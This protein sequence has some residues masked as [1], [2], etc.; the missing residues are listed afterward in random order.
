MIYICC[1]LAAMIK[2]TRLIVDHWTPMKR[3]HALGP[4]E[5]PST[6]LSISGATFCLYFGVTNTEPSGIQG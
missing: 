1:S 4:A 3:A 6:G 5:Q 2:C